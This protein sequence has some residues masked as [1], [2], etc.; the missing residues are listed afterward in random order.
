MQMLT[1]DRNRQIDER[2][3]H[4]TQDDTLMREAM[5][6]AGL[7]RWEALALPDLVHSLYHSQESDMPLLDGQIL[8]QCTA[9]TE[10]AGKKLV[11]CRQVQ[12]RLRVLDVVSDLPTRRTMGLTASRRQVV[13]RITEEAREQ[14]GL[15][16][17][18]D[19]A[20]IVQASERTIRRDVEALAQLGI[21]VATRGY[22]KDIGPTVSHKGIALRHWFAGQEPVAVARSINHS[23]HAVERYLV[24]FRRI[25]FLAMKGMDAV[26]IG[27][28]TR[29]SP[30]LVKTYRSIYDAFREQEEYAYRFEEICMSEGALIEEKPAN[31]AK[32]KDFQQTT[33]TYVSPITNPMKSQGQRT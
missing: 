31:G 12:V 32:K 26:T 5:A 24:D 2:L 19:V 7:T 4:K 28:I 17:Q 33:T 9:L 25:A 16:T 27:R 1:E 15:L 22:I 3:R 29:L 13:C 10:G 21:H 18:E 8:Y 20:F 14:G 30:S 11:D 6:G 23:L